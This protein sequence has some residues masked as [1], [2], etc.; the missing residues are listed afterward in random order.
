MKLLNV[1]QLK[2]SRNLATFYWL[3]VKSIRNRKKPHPSALKT[4]TDY[5]MTTKLRWMCSCEV[6]LVTA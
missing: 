3:F 4:E 6:Y 1:A 2:N 5:T